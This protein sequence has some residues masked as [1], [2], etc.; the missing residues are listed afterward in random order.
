[1]AA[2]LVNDTANFRTPHYHQPSDTL[3]NIDRTFFA[4]AAQI[5][6]NATASLLVAND[7]TA[8]GG[9]NP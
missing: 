9:I 7:P 1:V 8:T 3:A 5:V 4:G 2:V 6:A